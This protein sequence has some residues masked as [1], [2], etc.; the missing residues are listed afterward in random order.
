[1]QASWL[2]LDASF[3]HIPSDSDASTQPS[4]S[5]HSTSDSHTPP[6]SPD[7]TLV[8]ADIHSTNATLYTLLENC[9]NIHVKQEKQ[10]KSL[11]NL[12]AMS[13]ALIEG[14]NL[15]LSQLDTINPCLPPPQYVVQPHHAT[16]TTEKLGKTTITPTVVPATQIQMMV[17]SNHVNCLPQTNVPP[18]PPPRPVRPPK[19]PQSKKSCP[20]KKPVQTKFPVTG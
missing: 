12:L 6:C 3:D 14:M 17:V 5:N 19:P 11:R 8:P 16:L 15:I 2:L 20:H 10:S 13:K 1:M 7:T 4:P 9:M 18:W